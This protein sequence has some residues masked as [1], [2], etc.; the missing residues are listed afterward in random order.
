MARTIATPECRRNFLD[1]EDS[2]SL[3][4]PVQWP[5]TGYRLPTCPRRLRRGHVVGRIA[6]PKGAHR[7]RS[8]TPVSSAMVETPS[9]E[10]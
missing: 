3:R 6:R 7:P 9:G 8:G 5:I 1:Q 2:H 10:A 4:A